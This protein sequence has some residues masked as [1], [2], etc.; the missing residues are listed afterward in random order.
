MALDSLVIV[1]CRFLGPAV[2]GRG[3]CVRKDRRDMQAAK[4]VVLMLTKVFHSRLCLAIVFG[5]FDPQPLTH[6]H[7]D[8]FTFWP[9]I[10][11]SGRDISQS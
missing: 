2:S 8:R 5:F 3:P 6:R 7:A 1:D 10:E 4:F 11:F 9:D